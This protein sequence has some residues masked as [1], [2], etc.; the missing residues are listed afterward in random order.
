MTARLKKIIIIGIIAI[1]VV[2]LFGVYLNFWTMRKMDK[3]ALGLA[4][5]DF[6]Y[7]DYTEEE[8]AKM[9]PQ[10]KYADVATRITPEQTYAKFRQ[11]LK[12]NNLELAI[13]QL[14][15]ESGKRYNENKEALTQAH[16]EGR[17]GQIYSSYPEKIEKE[18][19]YEV[20]AQF[21]FLQKEGDE[22]MRYPLDFIKDVNGDWKLYSL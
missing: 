15:K 1:I 5:P 9:Y 21:Y 13:E 22:T 14:S 4:S 12:E 19:M 3:V 2:G 17:F 11:A 16:Q 7:A 10:I 6:P 20:R 18:N 8:L